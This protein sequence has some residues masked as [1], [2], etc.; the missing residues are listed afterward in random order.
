MNEWQHRANE[1]QQRRQ[2]IS[3]NPQLL[4]ATVNPA[5]GSGVGIA[6][7]SAPLNSMDGTNGHPGANSSLLFPPSSLSL[8]S[9]SIGA[10]S[11]TNVFAGSDNSLGG[12]AS[13]GVPGGKTRRNALAHTFG[14][15][16][17]GIMIMLHRVRQILACMCVVW[18]TMFI[19]LTSGPDPS[20]TSTL[21]SS[22]STSVSSRPIDPSVSAGSVSVGVHAFPMSQLEE[23]FRA[24]TF[25]FG[26][27][28]ELPPP[29][30][31]K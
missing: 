28:P 4:H 19:C 26:L 18:N 5:S 3:S 22:A 7:S 11:S 9:T 14:R 16:E 15:D 13:S 31:L 20:S 24:P 17:N 12:V 25:L 10:A 6:S 23:L 2:L 8:L 27:V 30:H 1:Q 29:T 21:P